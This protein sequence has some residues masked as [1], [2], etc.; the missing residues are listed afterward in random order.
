MGNASDTFT[1]I[2]DS[3]VATMLQEPDR[4][5]GSGGAML[6]YPSNL[7]TSDKPYVKY[8]QNDKSAI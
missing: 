6:V 2:I 7:N 8:F 3:R 1:N 5:E 4:H